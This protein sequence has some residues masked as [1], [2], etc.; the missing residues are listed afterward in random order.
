MAQYGWLIGAS[1]VAETNDH[2]LVPYRDR[3]PM[4]FIFL[5]SI[6]IPVPSAISSGDDN[7]F[8]ILLRDKSGAVVDGA[9]AVQVP[10]PPLPDG[11]YVVLYTMR[12]SH[13]YVPASSSSDRR[14]LHR[15][16]K[17]RAQHGLYHSIGFYTAIPH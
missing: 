7:T 5:L 3:S 6:D 4:S 16:D 1:T 14:P 13:Q 12:I 17:L 8:D 9:L 10:Y 2:H 11:P 15:M